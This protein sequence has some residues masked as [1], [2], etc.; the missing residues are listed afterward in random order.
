MLATYLFWALLWLPGFAVL[1]RW[2]PTSLGTGLMESLALAYAATFALLSPVSIACYWLELPVWVMSLGCVVACA[3]AAGSLA[4]SRAWGELAA[5]AR[6]DLGLASLLLL[7]YLWMQGRIGGWLD[8]DATFHL[9][10]IRHLLDHGFDNRDIYL[11]AKYFAHL[12]HTN[13]VHAFFASATQLT[14]GDPLE[15]WRASLPWAKLLIAAGHYALGLAVFGRREA[16]WLLALVVSTVQAG[17]TYAIYP[18]TLA[19]GWFA[20][21]LLAVALRAH[22]EVSRERLV[23][24]ALGSFTLGQVHAL[25]PLFVA[26][27]VGPFF[28]ARAIAGFARGRGVSRGHLLLLI[29]LLAGAPAGLVARYAYSAQARYEAPAAVDVDARPRSTPPRTTP[30]K[31]ARPASEPRDEALEA[32]GGHLE[33]RLE[34][35]ARGQWWLPPG[36]AGGFGFVLLGFAALGFG[37]GFSPRDRTRLAALAFAALTCA[38]LLFWPALCTF[39]VEKFGLRLA[40]PR[41]SP[42]L[43]SVLFAALAGAVARAIEWLG[44]PRIAWPATTLGAVALAT[45]LLGH[46]PRSFAEHWGDVAAGSEER[47]ETLALHR[48][49]RELLREHVPAGATVLASLREGRY[50][51]MLH[52]VHVIA[53]DRGHSRIPGIGE[54]RRDVE[55]M[56]ARGTP[57]D[58]RRALLRRYGVR[59]V[60]LR[61]KW[62]GRYGWAF[63]RGRQFGPSGEL[64]LV[65]LGPDL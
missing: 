40:L 22:D 55:R 8:G 47:H 4:R 13:L 50:V 32:G 1:R 25:Y 64:Y 16:A 48:A 29:A 51:V 45:Q 60:V 49:R 23:V 9:G 28:L 27:L 42:L 36:K 61:D 31:Q 52:D 37:L 59:Y 54:R 14:G 63:E 30:P 46:S 2:W 6:A 53:V 20:P 35:T 34:R 17:M 56:T 65:D 24:L 33:K 11:E 21:A 26:L 62:R 39:V 19:V 7:A 15:V 18:N 57:W 58:E 38:A 44:R 41:L 3:L 10:R 5:R 12:Y 43:G